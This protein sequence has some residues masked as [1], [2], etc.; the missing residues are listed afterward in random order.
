MYSDDEGRAWSTVTK[1]KRQ[2]N[3]TGGTFSTT[4]SHEKKYKVTKEQFK[5]LSTDEKLVSLYDMMLSFGSLNT[6]VNNLECSV[7]SLID[8][9]VVSDNR[10]K[11]LEYKSIDM[12]GAIAVTTLF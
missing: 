2:R 9:N 11:L 12:E 7:R 8:N 4:I 1:T 10:I 5:A 6:R 3:S